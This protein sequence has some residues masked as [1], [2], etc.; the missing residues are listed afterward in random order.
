MRPDVWSMVPDTLD[1]T[2]DDIGSWEM[3]ESLN[4]VDGE[5]ERPKGA[6][7]KPSRERYF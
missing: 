4:R 3:T 1:G 2:E 5:T 7:E 6:A